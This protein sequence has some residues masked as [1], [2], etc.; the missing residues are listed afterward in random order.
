MI[1]SS[2][3]KFQYI[4]VSNSSFD[5]LFFFDIT[6]TFFLNLKISLSLRDKHNVIISKA[7]Y[8]FFS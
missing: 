3:K 6:M 2:I 7:H 8:L 1:I 4:L 5:E